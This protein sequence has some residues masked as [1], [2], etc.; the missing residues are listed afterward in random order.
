MMIVTKNGVLANQKM[1]RVVCVAETSFNFQGLAEP[2]YSRS[3]R[4]NTRDYSY[5]VKIKKPHR[6]YPVGFGGMSRR[7]LVSR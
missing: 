4:A 2:I 3:D 6:F 7:G 5:F 1:E